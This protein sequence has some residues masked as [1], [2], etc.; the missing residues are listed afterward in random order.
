MNLIPISPNVLINAE[1]ICY[2]EQKK[3]KNGPVIKIGVGGK[4]FEV[5]IPLQQLYDSIGMGEQSSG[6]QHFA[7]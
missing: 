1:D 2:I 3:S 5:E 4:E 7:G 6:G